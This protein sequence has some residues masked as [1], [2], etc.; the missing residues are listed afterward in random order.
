MPSEMATLSAHIIVDP[1]QTSTKVAEYH[2]ATTSISA[3]RDKTAIKTGADTRTART[4]T[5]STDD[6]DTADTAAFAP[7]F[8]VVITPPSGLTA[9][10]DTS[11]SIVS[12]IAI[13]Q[14]S[15]PP[16]LGIGPAP[17]DADVDRAG[18][19]VVGSDSTADSQVCLHILTL[20]CQT[21]V[22]CLTLR[23]CT[24]GRVLLL[25]SL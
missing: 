18:Y 23:I 5:D 9:P 16:E 11:S 14:T 3:K 10:L 6:A 13:P 2:S 4:G 20:V 7:M 12:S 24:H 21:L 15:R 8:S 25:L 17:A 1:A 22:A 19:S